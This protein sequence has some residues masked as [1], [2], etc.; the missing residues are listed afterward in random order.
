MDN[1]QKSLHTEFK[2]LYRLQ[3][4]SEKQKSTKTTKH[5]QENGNKKTNKMLD[6]YNTGDYWY[7]HMLFK[8]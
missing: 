1:N 2:T 3:I 6:A 7:T 8:S 5:V 4:V